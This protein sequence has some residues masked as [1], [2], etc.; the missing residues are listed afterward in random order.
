MVEEIKMKYYAAYGT[1]ASRPGIFVIVASSFAEALSKL[2][3][4]FKGLPLSV[5][6]NTLA[7]AW[8]GVQPCIEDIEQ[9]K[10]DYYT[11]VTTS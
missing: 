7:E 11:R 2:N 1:Y 3:N 4:A 10:V 8:E 5:R 9:R 6:H